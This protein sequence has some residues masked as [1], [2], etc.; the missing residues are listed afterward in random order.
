[1][2]TLPSRIQRGGASIRLMTSLLLTRGFLID[3]FNPPFPG[4]TKTVT[5][6]QFDDSD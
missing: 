5:K 1:M 6:S 2:F 3:W 4:E